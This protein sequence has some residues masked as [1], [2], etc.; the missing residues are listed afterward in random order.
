MRSVL[1]AAMLVTSVFAGVTAFAGSAAA[2]NLNNDKIVFNGETIYAQNDAG[3][4]DGDW[5]GKTVTLYTYDDGVGTYV[6]Q[7]DA[8]ESGAIQFTRNDLEGKYIL[9]GPDQSGNTGLQFQ[10]VPQTLEF[11]KTNITTTTDSKDITINLKDTNRAGS[12]DVTVESN[13][14]GFTN[15]TRSFNREVDGGKS[16]TVPIEGLAKE[17]GTGNYTLNVN[18][19]DTAAN[20]DINLQLNKPG[21]VNAY[22]PQTVIGEERGDVVE[23][24]VEM[25]NTQT[26]NVTIGSAETNFV[27]DVHV[28][29]NNDDGKNATILLNTALTQGD[30]K[31]ISVKGSSDS[32]TLTDDVKYRKGTDISG[33][34]A[35]GNYEL[36]VSVPDNANEGWRPVNVATLAISQRST[37]SAQS[38]IAPQSSINSDTETSDLPDVVTQ[39]DN[40]A[41]GDYAIVQVKA[42]GLYGDLSQQHLSSD[43]SSDG[44]N[45]TVRD[46][47]PGPNSNV[48]SFAGNN[49]G[50]TLFQDAKNNTFYAAINTNSEALVN[51]NKKLPTGEWNATF[52]VTPEFHKLVKNNETVST[53]FTVEEPSATING[54]NDVVVPQGEVNI[55]GTTNLAPGTELT[56]QSKAGGNFLKS[57]TAEVGQSG[58]FSAPFDFS[59]AN[60]GTEFTVSLRNTGGVGSVDYDSISGTVSTEANVGETTTTSDSTTTTTTETTTTTTTTADTTT[61]TEETTTE[62]TTTT[63]QTGSI[64]GF[65]VA[66]SM[67]A[68][69]AAALL[70]LRRSN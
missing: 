19:T 7:Y 41:Q 42:S 59:N 11:K 46:A 39:R 55:T 48:T 50:V 62:E 34:L 60:N 31:F 58:N 16:I 15:V 32:L 4:D 9:Q 45:F 68:L 36:S 63:E 37:D 26:A 14:N 38:W 13:A 61:T 64:P 40:A 70:A 43:S 29:D 33:P 22:F 47:N 44:L 18:V 24:P 56:V 2:A 65:G 52:K 6:D 30:E 25:E 20:K 3:G 35:S 57:A 53:T 12:F 17:S 54:G 1:L 67:V 5:S 49:A 69:V 8:N 28:Q 27:A 51:G 23:I 10:V 21:K 66:V